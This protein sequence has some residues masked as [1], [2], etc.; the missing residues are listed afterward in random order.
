MASSASPYGLRPVNKLNGGVMNHAM[1]EFK[2]TTNSSTAI[3]TG[4]I[5]AIASGQPSA[6]TATPTTSSAGVVGVCM[7]V[8]YT[9]PA[10]SGGAVMWGQ[11]LP[12]DAITNGYTNVYILVCDDP[13][14]V[15]QVQGEAIGSFSGG[16]L[17]AVG[18][19]VA[20]E[21]FGGSTTTGLSTIRAD[22]GVNG[23]AIATTAT[24]AM[25]IVGVVPGTESDTYCEL[26]VKFNGATHSYNNTTGA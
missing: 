20:L 11:Y 10:A 18:R 17:A 24:L 5:I 3:Y 23:A 12:A 1:R 6:L 19:N 13:N 25:R 22:T 14:Q 15:F 21:N 4:D 8:R 16:A 26:L 7:G 9:L 2:M